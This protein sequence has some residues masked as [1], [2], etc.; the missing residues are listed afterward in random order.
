MAGRRIAG[1]GQLLLALVGFGLITAWFAEVFIQYYN[2]IN[3]DVP[4]HSVARLG[5]AGALTFIA[6]WL[7]ALVTSLS[8]LRQARAW[9]QANVPP[10]I[11]NLP[12]GM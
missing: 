5:E 3:G 7:W 4:A 11:T 9:E 8:L 2:Q 1:L 10:R 6:A 12:A